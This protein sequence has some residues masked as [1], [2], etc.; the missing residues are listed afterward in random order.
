MVTFGRRTT[1]KQWARLAMK[2]GLLI[3]D[4]KLWAA[5]NDQ[6]RERAGDLG[7]IVRDKYEVASDRLDDARG[8]L[9]GETDWVSPVAS[10]LGGVGIGVAVGMLF[11]PVSGEEARAAI[12]D[13][14]RD[15]SSKVNEMT[16]SGSRFRGTGTE[17]D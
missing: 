13:R 4:A 3:T 12:R 8:A 6:I 2:A 7:D 1:A 15:V 5:V 10:F 17:G 11:A 9:R 14:A 16:G